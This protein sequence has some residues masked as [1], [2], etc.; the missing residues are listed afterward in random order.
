MN[1]DLTEEQEMLQESLGGLLENEFPISR[2]R[3]VFD[4][5]T[6]HDPELWKSLIEL[7]IAGLA[8]DEAHGGAGL[9]VL[10][11][12]VAA[13]TLGYH[14]A[15]GPFLGHALAA[16][17]IEAGG[18]AEQKAKW[19]P[20][21]ATGDAVGTVALADADGGWLPGDWSIPVG[22]S[23]SG[24]KD[25]VTCADMADFMVVGLSGGR[26]G[27]VQREA[28][29][30]SLEPVDGADRTRRMS[31]V[32]FENTPC[33]LLGEGEAAAC[34]LRDVGLV[35]CAADALGGAQR[36]LEMSVEYSKTREQFG[37]TIGH[38]QSLKHQLANMALDVEP[39]RGLYW[40][41][42]YAQ[43]HET[44][45]AERI[46]ATAKAHV[47]DRFMQVSRD[48][49]EAHGGLGFTWECDVQMWFKRAMFDRAFLGTPSQHRSRSADLAGW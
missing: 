45:K 15:P 31:R 16:V 4:G 32:T 6:G 30:V 29:G 25:F 27:I 11:L 12:A 20:L 35:L 22:E 2:L 18:T 13:E 10:D 7:G 41:A 49:V 24:V 3:E 5:D 17:A 48:A 8:I 44:D 21:L 26:L 46:A 42:A 47:T 34:R 40:F 37:V 38:F 23:I 14:A 19:L 9:E 28:D 33:E 36:L 43:D 1:F 39:S